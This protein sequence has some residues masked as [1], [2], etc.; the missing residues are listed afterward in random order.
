M[1]TGG[2]IGLSDDAVD[3]F[4]VGLLGVETGF[5]ADDHEYDQ[6]GG[7]TDGEASDVERGGFFETEEVADGDFQHDGGAARMVP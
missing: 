6:G 5:K 1:N 4:I 2:V 7:D 3:V